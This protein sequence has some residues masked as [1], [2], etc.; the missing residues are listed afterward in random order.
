MPT[1][2]FDDDTPTFVV[3]TIDA[4]AFPGVGVVI[5]ITTSPDHRI[6]APVRRFRFVMLPEAACEAAALLIRLG[7]L[8]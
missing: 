7:N 5:T 3:E 6:S 2:L 8:P 1:P 4:E